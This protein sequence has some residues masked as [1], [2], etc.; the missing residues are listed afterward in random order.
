MEK[1]AKKLY[2]STKQKLSKAK[3]SY[4]CRS[5]KDVVRGYR[6][7]KTA[8]EERDFVKKESAHIRDLFREEDTTF[9]RQNVLKLLF[10]HMNG[11]PTEWGQL[12]CLKLCA[13]SRFK[14]KR[15]SL[16]SSQRLRRVD[17]TK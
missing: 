5:L 15:V 10:F 9:R 4:V 8:S 16:Y 1:E 3:R 12:E 7:C 11:Y 2:K 6:N 17:T 13:S 14:D